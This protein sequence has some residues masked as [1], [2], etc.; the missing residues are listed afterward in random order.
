MEGGV[1]D[2]P[3]G[4]GRHL[5][6]EWLPVD[7]SRAEH[8]QMINLIETLAERLFVAPAWSVGRTAAACGRPR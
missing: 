2:K 4:R 1:N 8:F 6:W 3:C 5:I 7:H